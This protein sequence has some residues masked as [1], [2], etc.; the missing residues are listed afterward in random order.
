LIPKLVFFHSVCA[1][2]LVDSHIWVHLTI[3]VH[4]CMCVTLLVSI[5]FDTSPICCRGLKCEP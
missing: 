1:L 3:W 4:V 2:G 5:V